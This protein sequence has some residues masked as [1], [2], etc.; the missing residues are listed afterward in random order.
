M[1]YKNESN[2]TYAGLGSTG[3]LAAPAI[4][5]RVRDSVQHPQ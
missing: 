4:I 2:I 1:K 3:Y 5:L